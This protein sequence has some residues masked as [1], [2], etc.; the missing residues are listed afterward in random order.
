MRTLLLIPVAAILLIIGASSPR[1]TVHNIDVGSFFFSPTKTVVSPGDTVRWTNVSGV[2]TT[3]SDPASPKAWDSGNLTVL[4]GNSLD[5][6]FSAGDGPGPFP[7]HCDFHP[8]TMKD[9]IF[10][11]AAAD[12]VVFAFLIDE[13]QAAACVGTG[14]SARGFGVAILNSD[15]STLSLYVEHDVAGVTAAHIHLAAKCVNGGISFGFA[16]PASPIVETWALS[17]GDLSDLLAGDLYVNIHSSVFPAGEIRGQI[18]QEPIKY[19]FTIDEAQADAGTGTGSFANG[20]SICELSADATELSVLVNHDV[21]SVTDGHIH[22]GAP[23]VNGSIV[24]GFTSPVSPVVES[25]ALDTLALRDLLGGDLYVNM[26]SSSFPAGEIRGQIEQS[27][28]VIATAIEESQANGGAGTG[29]SATGF[30]VLSLSPDCSELTIHVEHDV[31]GVTDGH[32]H[33]GAPGVNGAIQFG[34]ASASSPI[35]EV[36]SLSAS[37]VDDLLAGNLYIN[38][39]SS[40][41]PAGEIRG[42][43]DHLSESSFT[44]GLDESQAAACVGTGSSA[45]GSATVILKKGGKE[46]TIAASH[47]VANVTDGHIHL[48]VACVDGPIQF[49]IGSSSDPITEIWYLSEAD[50]INLLQKELYINIHSMAFPAGEIRGQIE[51]VAGGCCVGTRGDI[52]GDSSDLDI[53]DLTCV[54]DFLFGSGCVQPCAE[55]ADPNGDTSVSDIVDLTF[56]VDWLFGTAPT[57]VSCP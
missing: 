39:H 18:V 53:V 56:V 20:V 31:T 35:N 14:S 21:S 33:F 42:Q 1:A 40:A 30:A 36:W 15:S 51:D 27:G 8:F 34:F 19:A 13:A 25:W 54:V 7:Y 22:L 12:P 46:M 5:V 23:G 49:G 28:I 11:A 24:F 43:I 17:A 26:H 55:E 38:I 10:M 9:T 57:L 41:F 3:T 29:S 2:H 45:T 48:G 16:S 52:N 47:D 32:I 4:P 50:I 44:F 6:V 37:N